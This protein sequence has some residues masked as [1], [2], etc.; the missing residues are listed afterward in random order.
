MN[1]KNNNHPLDPRWVG[2]IFFA[3][4]GFCF[5]L[6][7]KY[8]LLSLQQ[9]AVMP[10]LPSLLVALI[11]GGLLGYIF[12]PFLIY[13]K[14]WLSIF[15]IGFIIAIIALILVSLAIILHLYFYD[16]TLI[17]RIHH[18]Q[19]YFIFYGTIF[20]SLTLILGF[21]LALF[22]G[23]ACVYFNKRFWPTLL[24][25]DKNSKSNTP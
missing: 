20:L 25:I 1:N 7:T 24:A 19:D 12:G 4:F 5:L 11:T 2:T 16:L 21:W 9:S 22:T 10:F 15:L 13:P 23:L 6:L 18:W 14:H 17:N 8:I 3:V